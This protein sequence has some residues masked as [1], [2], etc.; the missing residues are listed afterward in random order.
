MNG[1][2]LLD[3][4]KPQ[5]LGAFLFGATGL[6][7]LSDASSHIK[8][9]ARFAN[10]FL[11]DLV[12]V[13]SGVDDD[14]EIQAVLDAIAATGNHGQMRVIGALANCTS[15]IVPPSEVDVIGNNAEFRFTDIGSVAA[16]EFDSVVNS[17]WRD[18]TIRNTGTSG[19]PLIFKGTTDETCKMDNVLAINDSTAQGV[20]MSF[21]GT[22][23]PYLTNCKGYSATGSHCHGIYIGADGINYRAYPTMINCYGESRSLTGVDN[24]G[25]NIEGSIFGDGEETTLHQCLLIGCIG[26]GSTAGGTSKCHGF[27]IKWGSGIHMKGCIGYSGNKDDSVGINIEGNAS[28]LLENC[29][30]VGKG[31]VDTVHG[32]KIFK[33]A[34]P[35]LNNCTG[36]VDANNDDCAALF[37]A[38][39]AA[40]VINGFLGKHFTYEKVFEYTSADNG[41]FRP[42]T[43]YKYQITSLSIY[44]TTQRAVTIDVGTSIGGHEVCEAVSLNVYPQII[45]VSISR[46][47]IAANGYLYVT[48]SVGIPEGDIHIYYTVQRNLG[49][50]LRTEDNM[51]G[52]FDINHSTFINPGEA[53][54]VKQG[55]G[56]TGNGYFDKCKFISLHPTGQT[57]PSYNLGY[58]FRAVDCSFKN[59]IWNYAN[60]ALLSGFARGYRQQVETFV[61]CQVASTTFIVNAGAC[62]GAIPITFTIN[63]YPNAP[64]V[65]TWSLT[66]TNITAATL[67]FEIMDAQC[68]VRVITI[69]AA[70]AGWSGDIEWAALERCIIKM[71]ARTGSGAGDT[72]NVG[73]SNWFGLSNPIHF[74]ENV[75]AI[76]KAGVHINKGKSTNVDVEH[77]TVDVGAVNPGDDIS[78]YYRYPTSILLS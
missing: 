66:H 52:D 35:T 3:R 32:V 22:A 38:E 64:R 26:Q 60:P 18:L 74:W 7:V 57:F 21:G 47:M 34:T 42:F 20:G 76:K 65:L 50:P 25:W 10:L 36:I 6:V 23:H 62:D 77:S 69:D 53:L 54:P 71:T 1:I 73:I 2:G 8:S 61:D 45:P 29:T 19:H 51:S 9:A 43:T 15:Q 33:A 28:P 67:E 70:A 5:N 12:K 31:G 39:K 17:F 48:P 30:G 46:E 24:E 49:T 58:L 4:I 55:A 11:G 41:R 40:P 14:V 59:I 63:N 27:S 44:N 13:C 78:I 75:R 68:N 37:I 72:L 56:I 16:V